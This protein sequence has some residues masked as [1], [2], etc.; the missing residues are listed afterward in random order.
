MVFDTDGSII[1]YYYDPSLASGSV[2]FPIRELDNGNF[3]INFESDVRE[4]DLQGQIVREITLTQLNTALAAAG[5]S[6]QAASIHH[7]LLRLSNGHWIL[8]LNEYR[9]FQD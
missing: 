8:L 9:D 6:L 1:W 5:Y 2:A 3:L 7:D 4:V